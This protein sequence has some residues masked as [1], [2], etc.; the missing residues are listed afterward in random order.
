MTSL[1]IE[2]SHV[3]PPRKN[4]GRAHTK[5]H[6]FWKSLFIFFSMYNMNFIEIDIQ[7]LYSLVYI[8]SY[9]KSNH[10]FD[11]YLVWSS[12]KMKVFMWE[13]FFFVIWTVLNV[14][15]MDCLI[16]NIQLWDIQLLTI[17]D[18]SQNYC[19]YIHTENLDL[20]NQKIK[21]V[22]SLFHIDISVYNMNFLVSDTK[23][24]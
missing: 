6:F 19:Y 10:I 2:K 3:P 13:I 21:V 5:F 20:R 15:N 12:Q 16:M 4:E 9:H 24:E 8:P 22:P 1:K 17:L 18:T 14:Y 11:M 7:L 23:P